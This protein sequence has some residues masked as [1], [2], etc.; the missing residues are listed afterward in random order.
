MPLS[1]SLRLEGDEASPAA[2]LPSL[3]FDGPEIVLGRANGADV[4]IPDL[5]AS[6]LHAT[7]LRDGASYSI[8]DEGGA[9]GTFVGGVRVA[10]G[11]TRILAS[12]DVVRI[13]RV[14]ARI[15]VDVTMPPGAGSTREMALE[16]LSK[17]IRA[18]DDET[19]VRVV[20]GR[21]RGTALVLAEAS[22]RYIL[23]RE[24]TAD[25]QIMD[26]LASREHV[27][28]V[29][30]GNDVLVRDL[31]A[32]NP[33]VLG[34]TRLMTNRS[35]VWHPFTHLRIGKIVLALEIPRGSVVSMLDQLP[36]ST[37][38]SVSVDKPISESNAVA[39]RGDDADGQE[40]HAAA[41]EPEVP[42][43]A[44]SAPQM[45]APIAAP[46]SMPSA[47]TSDAPRGGGRGSLAGKEKFI[48]AV[49]ASILVLCVLGLVWIVTGRS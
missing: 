1:L 5:E 17:L 45:S 29:R 37:K 4:P 49:V 47:L 9:I 40:S 33:A 12:G 16:V 20:E 31:G 30:E 36:E 7:I 41:G 15:T 44:G 21:R 23:G 8:R 38:Q 18:D 24:V 39:R 28:L 32:K 42:R 43:P 11:A 35:V 25:L 14:E 6:P 10:S 3:S 22:R 19:R 13:G 34:S 26:E 27:E 46:P 48:V 2:R